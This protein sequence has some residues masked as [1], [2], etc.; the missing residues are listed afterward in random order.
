MSLIMNNT[1]NKPIFERNKLS[2]LSY[3]MFEIENIHVDI[4]Y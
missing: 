4:T 2:I 1:E 3:V